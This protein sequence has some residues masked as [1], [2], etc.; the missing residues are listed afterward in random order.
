MRSAMAKS[1][2]EVDVQ[3]PDSIKQAADAFVPVLEAPNE[4]TR[5]TEVIITE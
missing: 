5:E 4:V 2:A 1:L 3:N